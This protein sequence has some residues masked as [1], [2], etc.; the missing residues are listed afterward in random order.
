MRLGFTAVSTE[1]VT[2]ALSVISTRT[3]VP[4]R[5]T[6]T[7]CTVA[8]VPFCAAAQEARTNTAQKCFCTTIIS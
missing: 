7:F 4:S 3:S 8:V 5:A 2:G 6:V 1:G